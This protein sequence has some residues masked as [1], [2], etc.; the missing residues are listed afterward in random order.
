MSLMAAVSKSG[1]QGICS[2]STSELVTQLFRIGLL[3]VGSYFVLD[4]ELTPG[5]L[6]S[7]RA[8][9]GY[10]TGPAT[11]LMGTN[12]SVQDALIAADHL[13][14]IIDLASEV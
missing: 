7:F 12:K 14:E 6:L 9:V 8:I 10:F 2:G 3:W 5:E 1:R 13:F 11:A 4:N